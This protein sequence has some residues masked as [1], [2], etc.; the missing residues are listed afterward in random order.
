MNQGFK[1]D[2]FVDSAMDRAVCK[3]APFRY[4]LVMPFSGIGRALTYGVPAELQGVVQVGS[5][6]EVT[7]RGRSAFGVVTG[8]VETLDFPKNRLLPIKACPYAVP[9]ASPELLKMMAWMQRYYA[10]SYES[11]LETM[12]PGVVR[13]GMKAKEE[14]WIALLKPLDDDA[15]AKLRKRAPKQAACYAFVVAQGGRALKRDV[16]EA[17]GGSFQLSKSLVKEGVISET[18]E[19]KERISYNDAIAESEQHTAHSKP[20]VLNEEQQ[21]AA[22]AVGKS[23]EAGAYQTHLLHGVT[24]SGKTEVYFDAIER[25]LKSGGGAIFLVP[26]VV[27]TPQTVGRLRSRLDRLGCKTVVWHSHLSDGERFDA[28]MSLA[29][30][31]A[32]IVVGARSAIFAPVK[33]LRLVIVDEEHEPAYKQEESP[34]YQARDVAVYRAMLNKAVCVLGSATPSLESLYNTRIKGYQLNRLTQRIDDR[35]LPTFHVIDMKYERTKGFAPL[36]RVLVDKLFDRFEKKEQSILFLNRRGFSSSLLCPDCGY[37]ANCQHCSRTLTYHRTD[38][39]LRC[40]LCAYEEKAPKR[41]PKCRSATVQW[42]GS[43]TQRVEEATQKALP[44]AKVVRIDADALSKRHRF[45]EILADFRCGK[46]D[47]LVGTQMIAKGLDFPNVTLVGMIDADLS[48]HMPDF[49]A[50]ERTFQLLVQVAG[51]AGR[52]DQAGEVVVQSFSPSSDPIQF[53]R[54]AD[55]DGFLDAELVQRKEFNYPPFR[56][57]IRHVFRGQNAEKVAFFCES[58]AK[59]LEK[60]SIKGVEIRGPAP[61]PLEKVKDFY[62]YHLWY[63]VEN[64]SATI[65]QLVALREQFKSDKEVVDVID[66]D[67]MDLS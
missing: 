5:L 52:G 15:L 13:K 35:K 45:R 19:V 53:A 7:I 20:V 29:K 61:A 48:L 12:I 23:L 63:F 10:A 59:L 56:H 34:R 30:G 37:I 28:W 60:T 49:R 32:Q 36:S 43:G 25:V 16:T 42:R 55:F 58:W 57:L 66:V 9:M 62:R 31:E 14:R 33:N 38:H 50:A 46:I 65:P 24:G 3:T 18:A 27:L 21:A 67:P 47:V 40:H 2:S 54:Q 22:D 39:K 26:E 51:R 64:V 1:L 6:V 11:V 17:L 4:A 41:C 44:G 8:S